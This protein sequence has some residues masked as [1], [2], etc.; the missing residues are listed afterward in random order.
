LHRF[1]RANF[2]VR[3]ESMNRPSTVFCRWAARKI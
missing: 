3:A 2:I 1:H